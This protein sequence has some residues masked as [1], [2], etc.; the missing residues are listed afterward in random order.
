MD[1]GRM[2]DNAQNVNAR[3]IDQYGATNKTS[4]RTSNP[5]GFY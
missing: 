1:K 4:V 5:P 2:M 3:Y